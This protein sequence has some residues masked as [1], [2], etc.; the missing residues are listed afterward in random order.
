MAAFQPV[1]FNPAQINE[2]R[3]IVGNDIVHG[4]AGSQVRAVT[5]QIVSEAGASFTEQARAIKVTEGG[6]EDVRGR[7]G[8]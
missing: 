4:A 6:G 7:R 2:I 5:S 1:E 3:M 8:D